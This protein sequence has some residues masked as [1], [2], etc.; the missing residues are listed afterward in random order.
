MFTRPHYLTMFFADLIH[1]KSSLHMFTRTHYLTMFFA[2]LIH[3]KSSLHMFTRP[4]Y[5][6]M[7][8]AGLIHSKSSL[9][10]LFNICVP[11]DC[12]YLLSSTVLCTVLMR[13]C[14][15]QLSY[16]LETPV[17]L[18][19]QTVIFSPCW[20]CGRRSAQPRSL[21]L[22]LAIKILYEMFFT[23]Y[24]ECTPCQISADT[25]YSQL[26][27]YLDAVALYRTW[28]LTMKWH[29]GVRSTWVF[30]LKY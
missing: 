9:H 3:S 10:I 12:I 14:W 8:F 13:C 16:P 29:E 22:H 11:I 6:T 20:L 15:F 27:P 23:S 28:P 18:K 5:L 24:Q 30:K 25:R 1:S 2:G 7:F 19:F 4:H 17:L 26:V 21:L